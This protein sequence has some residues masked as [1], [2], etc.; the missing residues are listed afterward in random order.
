MTV[1][2]L[3][4]VEREQLDPATVVLHLCGDLDA[5]TVAEFR[6]AAARNRSVGRLIIDLGISFI[7]SAGLHALVTAVIQLRQHRGEAAVVSDRPGTR[8]FL[9]QTG[10]ERVATVTSTV[11]EAMAAL[12]VPSLRP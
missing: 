12:A 9:I 7:D 1:T 5:F 11:E 4:R 6:L 8:Q 2:P 3:L 10:F